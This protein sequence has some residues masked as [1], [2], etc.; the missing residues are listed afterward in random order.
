VHGDR[1]LANLLFR[2]FVGPLHTAPQLP[3]VIDLP[4]PI[5]DN[6]C[7]RGTSL[8]MHIGVVGRAIRLLLRLRDCSGVVIP[9]PHLCH[10]TGPP[11]RQVLQHALTADGSARLCPA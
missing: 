6:I 9:D 10:L 1:C 2:Q 11:I 7:P 5:I 3:E 4:N 8:L